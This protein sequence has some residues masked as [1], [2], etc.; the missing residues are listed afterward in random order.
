[1]IL[2]LRNNLYN[3]DLEN[4]NSGS[5]EISD[6][7]GANGVENVTVKSNFDY[8]N[9]NVYL[10]INRQSNSNT[11]IEIFPIFQGLYDDRKIAIVDGKIALKFTQAWGCGLVIKL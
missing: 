4:I 10:V 3:N 5:V 7:I 2:Y 6:F 1:M 9:S 11:D 8:V